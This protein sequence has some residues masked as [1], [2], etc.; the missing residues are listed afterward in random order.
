ME[1]GVVGGPVESEEELALG[2]A[3]RDQVELTREDLAWEHGGR[4]EQVVG[5]AARTTF[6][7]VARRSVRWSA[8]C[9]NPAVT[10]RRA[11][12]A[13]AMG[14]PWFARRNSDKN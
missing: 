11:A 8:T 3:A 12:S 13:G 5:Q 7:G 10:S 14:S 1:E 9:P 4:A 2:A 6:C